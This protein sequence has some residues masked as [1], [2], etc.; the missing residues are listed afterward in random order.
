MIDF[1]EIDE[2]KKSVKSINLDDMSIEDLKIY[3]RELE[4]EVERVTQEVAKK[5]V[6]RK[7]ADNFF[8]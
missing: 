8:K 1:F 7:S 4:K 2:K 5:E 6:F 3:I